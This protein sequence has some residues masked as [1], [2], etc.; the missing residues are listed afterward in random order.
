M[1]V[2]A[3]HRRECGNLFGQF[4][5]DP[6]FVEQPEQLGTVSF[7]AALGLV[8]SMRNDALGHHGKG[9][10]GLIGAAAANAEHTVRTPRDEMKPARR[11][12]VVDEKIISVGGVAIVRA[13]EALHCPV[14][15]KLVEV[16]YGFETLKQSFIRN[17][18]RLHQ[19][20]QITSVIFLFIRL[21]LKRSRQ[22]LG[23]ITDRTLIKITAHFLEVPFQER[24]SHRLDITV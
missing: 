4:G 21:N 20:L 7:S 6:H 13:D 22:R 1:R 3:K 17:C 9:C 16:D 18:S 15:I 12:I 8:K 19:L 23:E 5:L 10:A 14:S 24:F 2:R 11:W